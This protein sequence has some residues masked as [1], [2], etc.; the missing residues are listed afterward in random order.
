MPWENF[1][2][3]QE[4]RKADGSRFKECSAKYAVWTEKI[5]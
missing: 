1:I 5:L 3:L 2:F 4:T